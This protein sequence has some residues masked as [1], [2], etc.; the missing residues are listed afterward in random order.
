LF[1][2]L[3]LGSRAEAGVIYGAM[4]E[5]NGEPMAG[6]MAL[7]FNDALGPVPAPEQYFRIPDGT[8]DLD[9]DGSFLHNL[10]AGEYYIGA[11][12]NL[13]PRMFG[14][15]LPGDIFFL[16]KDKQGKPKKYSVPEHGTVYIGPQ[17]LGTPYDPVMSINI[18]AIAGT[19]VDLAGK[20]VEGVYVF[21][22]KGLARPNF[23]SD[24]TSEDGGY[25]LRVHKGGTYHLS[26]RSESGERTLLQK[27]DRDP[28]RYTVLPS[29][30]ATVE[31]GT[32]RQNV[33][34][35]VSA[36]QRTAS[37]VKQ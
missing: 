37:P 6:G 9:R 19:I 23:I 33:N 28:S 3:L 2:L 22:A 11:V 14:P 5:K 34:L 21:A 15:P 35:L 17:A 26:I 7:F 31:S 1:A 20:P 24:R 36:G 30:T 29:I 16:I 10:P 12:K 32:T 13:R 8:A 25:L 18:T 27:N 4:L